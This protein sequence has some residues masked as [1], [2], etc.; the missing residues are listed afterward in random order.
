[1]KKK[2]SDNDKQPGT[3]NLLS[4]GNNIHLVLIKTDRS[5]ESHLL[6]SHYLEWR[7]ILSSPNGQIR[8]AVEINGVG[9]ESKVPVGI[10][11]IKMD[12][13]PRL[14]QVCKYIHS[15]CN[16]II[17]EKVLPVSLCVCLS[18]QYAI[19]ILPNY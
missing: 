17:G 6:G 9:A 2:S 11:D 8:N 7:G 13:I 10:I 12:L 14:S 5:G 18:I 4:L 19:T 1:M 3:R 16:E 15:V